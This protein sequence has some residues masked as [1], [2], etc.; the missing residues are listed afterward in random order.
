M[1]EPGDAVLLRDGESAPGRPF[2]DPQRSLA[3]ILAVAAMRASLGRRSRL[4]AP[5]GRWGDSGDRHWLVAPEPWLLAD[6]APVHAIGFFGQARGHVDHEPIVRLEHELL[7][8]AASFPGLVAYLNVLFANGQWGNLVVF[9][10]T[11]GAAHV[12]GDPTHVE[13]LACTPGH[14]HSVRLHRLRLPDGPA[15]TAPLE[16]LSTLL[17]D[18]DVSPPWRAVRPG[19]AAV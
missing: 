18:F 3:D 5:A 13:A 16:H 12:R 17:L 6:E 4:P 14:Y 8:R 19:G 9:A 11:D 7:A 1:P 10:T 15:G 2:T